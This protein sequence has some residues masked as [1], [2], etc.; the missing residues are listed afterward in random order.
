VCGF[1]FV[2]GV[3]AGAMPYERSLRGMLAAW[4]TGTLNACYGMM[5]AVLWYF[6]AIVVAMLTDRWLIPW[7]RMDSEILETALRAAWFAVA[8]YF[9]VRSLF[10]SVYRVNETAGV[11]EGDG[12]EK[13][14]DV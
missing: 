5:W 1:P 13:V 2:C 7:G 4:V 14:E 8:N 3:V 12:K 9:C 6:V 11:V 10:Y